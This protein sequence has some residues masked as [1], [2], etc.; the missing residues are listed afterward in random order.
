MHDSRKGLRAAGLWI[1]ALVC[2]LLFAAAPASAES[3]EPAEVEDVTVED[4]APADVEVANIVKLTHGQA[5]TMLRKVGGFTIVS[6]GNCSNRANPKCTSLTKVN[7]TTVQGIIAFRKASKCRIKITGG[8]ETGHATMKY[9]HWNGYKVDID[10]STCVTKYVKKKFKRSGTCGGGYAR[11]KSPAGN[12]YCL[13][14]K[15]N[16]FDITYFKPKA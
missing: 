2:G 9:S 7:K 8:T 1:S 12:V 14:S 10:D 15:K 6:S 3:I 13:E 16:H 11:W 4:L 5:V